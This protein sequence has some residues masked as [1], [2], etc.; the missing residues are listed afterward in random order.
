MVS[1][2]VTTSDP[3]QALVGRPSSSGTP[4]STWVCASRP[5]ASELLA[6]AVQ[7][8]PSSTVWG[9]S[10]GGLQGFT[11]VEG[12]LWLGVSGFS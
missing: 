4:T 12:R 10:E 1:G 7:G 9:C 5:V 2:S 11:R 8:P 6:S 3:P